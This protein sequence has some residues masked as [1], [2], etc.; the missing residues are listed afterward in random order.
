MTPDADGDT[1]G[2]QFRAEI[3]PLLGLA[4]ERVAV[5]DKN[6]VWLDFGDYWVVFATFENEEESWRFFASDISA[7]YLVASNSWL[8]FSN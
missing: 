7:P 4:V 8:K 1:P 6:D 2:K 5:S 3:Q